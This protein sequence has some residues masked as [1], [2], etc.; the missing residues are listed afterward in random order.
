MECGGN[1]FDA[2]SL[3]VKA[4]LFNT[5][6]PKVTAAVLDGGCVDLALSDDPHDCDR[7]NVQHVPILVTLCK[8]GDD[9][10]VDPSAEEEECSRAKL[11]IGISCPETGN[12]RITATRTS[13]TGSLHHNTLME[14]LKLGCMAGDCL[15]RELM[16]ILE[17]DEQQSKGITLKTDVFGFLK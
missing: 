1:L 15:N 9:C 2:V 10:L 5:K 17:V 8:I 12:P 3:A 7:I 16:K 11:V 14:S 6:I 4:A 13:G